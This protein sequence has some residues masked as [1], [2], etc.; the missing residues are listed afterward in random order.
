MIISIAIICSS[1]VGPMFMANSNE[2]M[3]LLS[4]M[5][6]KFIKVPGDRGRSTINRKSLI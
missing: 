2:K 6:F 1:S 5:T 3:S 4:Q